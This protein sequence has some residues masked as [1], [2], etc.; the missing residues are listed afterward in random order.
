MGKELLVKQPPYGNEIRSQP[1]A[2]V[3]FRASHTAY[4]KCIFIEYEMWVQYS[5]N[6]L[7]ISVPEESKQFSVIVSDRHWCWHQIWEDEQPG[8][9]QDHSN[10][11]SLYTFK[12]GI[13]SS[14]SGYSE[15]TTS[16]GNER[17]FTITCGLWKLLN[18][19]TG[20]Q[21]FWTPNNL[22]LVA[23]FSTLRL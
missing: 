13:D 17:G 14:G 7:Q 18:R 16:P 12:N 6:K 19:N 4:Y 9:A 20:S 10:T 23:C 15:I 1:G 22:P 2:Q 21:C 8:G 5:W 3:G 11:I